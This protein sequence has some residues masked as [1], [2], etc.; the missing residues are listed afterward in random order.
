MLS[1]PIIYRNCYK[2]SLLIAQSRPRT[3]QPGSVASDGTSVS[4]RL[5]LLIIQLQQFERE[6][7]DHWNCN[8]FYLACF[9][10]M[11]ELLQR[12]CAVYAKAPGSRA[13]QLYEMRPDTEALTYI[14]GQC[15][16]VCARRADYANKTRG[17]LYFS[18]LQFFNFNFDR[19]ALHLQP[20]PGDLVKLSP[21]DF[22]GRVHRRRLPD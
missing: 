9:S 2:L 11:S 4:D 13:S 21:P 10:K 20:S 5:S 17:I 19:L 15:S 7:I 16:D 6:R 12:D 3:V 14:F 18:Q 8:S 22:L 1:I